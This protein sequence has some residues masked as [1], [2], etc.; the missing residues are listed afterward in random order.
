MV[1]AFTGIGW[2]SNT[3]L[4]MHLSSYILGGYDEKLHLR[5][6]FGIA[7]FAAT[8]GVMYDLFIDPLFVA[9]EVWV[10]ASTEGPWY[11]IPTLNF[12]G[13]FM[14]IFFDTLSYYL[15][16]NYGDSKNKKVVFGLIAVLLAS[17]TIIFAMELGHALNIK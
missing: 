11:G 6:I 2:I 12:I 8:I 10:W 3:Y 7:A 1:A 13:W 16:L 9:L 17:I 4:S 5:Q 15:V 14:I